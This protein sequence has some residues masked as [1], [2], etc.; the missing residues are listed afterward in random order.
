MLGARLYYSFH[1]ST[2]ISN[3]AF[4]AQ[5]DAL[6]K[7][8]G[9][10]GKCIAEFDGP[11]PVNAQSDPIDAMLTRAPDSCSSTEVQSSAM[12]TSA[13]PLLEPTGAMQITVAE[14]ARLLNDQRAHDERMVGW[15][16]ISAVVGIGVGVLLGLQLGR[17]APR[18]PRG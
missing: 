17:V 10:R 15:V 2:L 18:E 6:C 5:V 3:S 9:D 1:S 4:E 7:E 11:Q 12:I 16:W 13:L 14:I 8:L